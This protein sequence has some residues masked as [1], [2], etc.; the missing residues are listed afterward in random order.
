MSGLSRIFTDMQNFFI[1]DVRQPFRRMFYP[2]NGRQQSILLQSAKMKAVIDD[3][4]QLR[5][6]DTGDYDDLLNMLLCARYEDTGE[7]MT[8]EALI[9]EVLVLLLA[10]HDT[11]ANAL[12]WLLHL[13]AGI[14]VVTYFFGLHRSPAHWSEAGTFRPERFLDGHGRIR[15]MNAFFPF[16][17]RPPDVHRKQF[18]DGGDVLFS[19][20]FLQPI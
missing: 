18:R 2:L 14:V 13:V 15:K 8:G 1:D 11:T 20:G 19:L 17:R 9:T 12:A 6:N 4:I 3:I 10:G 5:R 16:W 7:P